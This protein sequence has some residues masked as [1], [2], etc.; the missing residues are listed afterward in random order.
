MTLAFVI[1]GLGRIEL[2]VN[3]AS[4]VVVLGE[5][6]FVP[7]FDLW[8]A[9]KVPADKL[10]QAMCSMHFFRNF[11]NMAGTFTAGVLFDLSISGGRPGLNWIITGA[12]AA[13]AALSLAFQSKTIDANDGE[14]QT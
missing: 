3:C 8:V 12:L 7:A 11:G 13:T 6:L 2:W 9:K 5:I 10:A 4:A 14:L 1:L